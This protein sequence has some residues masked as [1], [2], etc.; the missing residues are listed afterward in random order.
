MSRLS[1]FFLRLVAIVSIVNDFLLGFR[2]AEGIASGALSKS[3]TVIVGSWTKVARS[4]HGTLGDLSPAQQSRLSAGS[5]RLVLN[6]RERALLET[7]LRSTSIDFAT[8]GC[9]KD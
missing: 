2:L 5:S 7:L 8:P 4:W 1:K 3:V 9:F 6:R